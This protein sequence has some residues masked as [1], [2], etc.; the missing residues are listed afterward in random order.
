[1]NLEG[2]K[3]GITGGTGMIGHSLVPMLLDKGVK[4]IFVASLDEIT[5]NHPKVYCIKMDLTIEESCHRICKNSD[6]IFNLIGIKTSPKIMK[7]KPADI[8]EKY[9]QFTQNLHEKRYEAV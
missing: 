2:K 1:M 6:I 8:F 4:E 7:E 5:F 3:I 9:L